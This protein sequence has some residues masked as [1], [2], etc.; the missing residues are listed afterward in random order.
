MDEWNETAHPFH[1]TMK[2][3]ARIM[4]KC[5]SEGSKPLA[6]AASDFRSLFDRSDTDQ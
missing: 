1:W 6:T 3:M 2:S 5:Q 4:A